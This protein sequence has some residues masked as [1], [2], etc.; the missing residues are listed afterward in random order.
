M[1]KKLREKIVEDMKQRLSAKRFKHVLA[2]ADAA[3]KLGLQRGR[4]GG[5]AGTSLRTE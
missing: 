3:G 4:C 1:N 2:V 5:Q